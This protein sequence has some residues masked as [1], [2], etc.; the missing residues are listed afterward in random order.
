MERNKL[1]QFW[2]SGSPIPKQSFEMGA[3]GQGFT[4]ESVIAWAEYVGTEANIAMREQLQRFNQPLTHGFL[5][6]ELVFVLDHNRRM[7][8]D[9]LSKC[10]LDAMNQIVYGDDSQVINLNIWKRWNKPFIFPGVDPKRK[11]D[12]PGY[13]DPRPAGVDI[14]ILRV[15]A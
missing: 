7:D 4:K 9:N 13:M 10:V 8:C 12:D 11:F 14:T 5:A 1:L 6:V 2:V 3:N 15:I